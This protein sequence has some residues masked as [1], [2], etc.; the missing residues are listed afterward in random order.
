MPR[1]NQHNTTRSQLYYAY[2]KSEGIA[3]QAVRDGDFLKAERFFLKAASQR[4][5]FRDKFCNGVWDEGHEARY[6]TCVGTAWIQRQAYEDDKIIDAISYMRGEQQTRKWS[7]WEKKHRNV[8]IESF[9]SLI[10]KHT[11]IKKRRRASKK[12]Q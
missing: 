2:K 8:G 9:E 6:Q 7:V 5:A 1:S 10:Q 12:R 4:L 3:E 11:K